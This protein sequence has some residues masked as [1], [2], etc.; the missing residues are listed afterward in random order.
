MTSLT[1]G[2]LKSGQRINPNRYSVIPRTLT[3]L[4]T[5]DQVLLLRLA[6]DRGAWAGKFNG[7]GGHVEQAED[8]LSAA[9]REVKEE[10]GITPS[11]LTLCGLVHIDVGENP[12]ISLYI[13]VGETHTPEIPTQTSEGIAEWQ[14]ISSLENLP[15]VEDLL[16]LFPKA[17]EAY[18]AKKPFSAS[19]KLNN[20][21]KINI[22]FSE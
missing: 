8:P 14:D 6:S 22:H 7:V 11:P 16:L 20:D 12:G 4:I 2:D 9:L 19:Y 3:F 5:D 18:A 17:L 1:D 21:G 10:T 15:V 13:Y